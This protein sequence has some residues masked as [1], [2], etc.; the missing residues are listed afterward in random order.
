MYRKTRF[1][2]SYRY[3]NLGQ[4][5]PMLLVYF[6]Q[7]FFGQTTLTKYNLGLMTP[8]TGH[9]GNLSLLK[10]TNSLIAVNNT[11][12]LCDLGPQGHFTHYTKYD[13]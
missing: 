1:W 4:K 7:F 3:S 8:P 6:E 10:R 11:L 2:A 12:T 13:I 9:F 5:D